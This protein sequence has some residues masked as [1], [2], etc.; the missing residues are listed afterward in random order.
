MQLLG[1]DEGRAIGLT[2]VSEIVAVDTVT[3]VGPYP[4]DLQRMTT[5]SAVVAA[6]AQ[7]T[8]AVQAFLG[9]L[10][11]PRLKARLVAGGYEAAK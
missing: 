8:P 7:L 1:K 6:R 5:Y 3:L 4:G 9:F 10:A 11:S 2:Q